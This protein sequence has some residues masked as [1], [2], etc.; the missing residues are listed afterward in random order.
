M[1]GRCHGYDSVV[2]ENLTV[3]HGLMRE[4]AVGEIA[5]HGVVI[6]VEH[7]V[8]NKRRVYFIS[9]DCCRGGIPSEGDFPQVFSLCNI[10]IGRWKHQRHAYICGYC[11]VKPG[12]AFIGGHYAIFVCAGFG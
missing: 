9:V 8:F 5:C 10:D 4:G 3:G 11:G 7:V 2:G 1:P 6:F 12:A